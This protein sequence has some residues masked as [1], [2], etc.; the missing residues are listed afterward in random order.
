[1][2]KNNLRIELKCKIKSFIF[3]PEIWFE[4]TKI[5]HHANQ[6]GVSALKTECLILEITDNQAVEMLFKVL[7]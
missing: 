1:M 6:T 7:I 3:A 4:A 2:Q 5:L